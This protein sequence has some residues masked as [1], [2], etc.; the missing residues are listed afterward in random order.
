MNLLSFFRRTKPTPP[1]EPQLSVPDAMAASTAGLSYLQ[2]MALTDTER[3][4]LRWRVRM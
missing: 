4:D 3:A 1:V 2:W